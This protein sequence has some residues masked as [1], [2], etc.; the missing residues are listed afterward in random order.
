M[1]TKAEILRHFDAFAVGDRWSALYDDRGDAVTNYSFIVRRRRVEALLEPVLGDGVRVLDVGCGTGV[2]A[3]FV[4]AR[5]GYYSG[6]DVS[7]N[8]ID[9]ARRRAEAAMSDGAAEFSVGDGGRIEQPDGHFDAVISLGVL[10]YLSEPA[11]VVAEIVRVTKPGG[12]IIVSVPNASCM[13]AVA[14]KVLSPMVTTLAR[15]IRGMVGAARGADH[16]SHRKYR[17]RTLDGFFSALGCHK[18]GRAF[19]NMEIGVYPVRRAVPRAALCVK[20]LA[21]SRADGPLRLFATG[22]IGR[23]VTDASGAADRA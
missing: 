12:T 22:Y 1:R 17:P 2:M 21:E 15:T 3:E 11:T 14:D 9:T 4:V 5:G 13:D 19:Y 23:Y 16:Y 6:L 8:M 20:R 18:S 10:E 7:R